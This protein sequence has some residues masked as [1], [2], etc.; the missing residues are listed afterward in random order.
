MDLV[1]V[2]WLTAKLNTLIAQ[3]LQQAT[4]REGVLHAEVWGRRAGLVLLNDL[5]DES[6]IEPTAQPST[7]RL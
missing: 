1:V 3:E 7:R 5:S 4:L 6:W 2:Q